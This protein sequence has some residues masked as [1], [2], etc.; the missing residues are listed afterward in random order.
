M[1]KFRL[2]HVPRD[3]FMAQRVLDGLFSAHIDAATIQ[4]EVGG[5]L[6]R[7][8]RTPLLEGV[9]VLVLMLSPE[10]MRS[11]WLQL[12]LL[13]ALEL[14]L[15]PERLTVACLLFRDCLMPPLLQ[16]RV[17]ADLRRT[18]GFAS[19]IANL[20]RLVQQHTV[21]RMSLERSR[22]R[23]FEQATAGLSR[24]APWHCMFCGSLGDDP[25]NCYLCQECGSFRPY[26]DLE[27]PSVD[28]GD[29]GQASLAIA[30]YCEWCGDTIQGQSI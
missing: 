9:D 7:G 11:R 18:E 6:S 3:R 26:V 25:E 23:R 12:E 2:C 8:R 13:P 30:Q 17:C 27:A 1:L 19:G 28:C 10:S 5:S 29:C 21:R 22:S 16:A 15:M 24:P 14:R 4:L 20:T